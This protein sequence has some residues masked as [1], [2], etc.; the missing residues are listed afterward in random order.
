MPESSS[1]A[2]SKALIVLSETT[3]APN[4]WTRVRQSITTQAASQSRVCGERLFRYSETNVATTAARIMTAGS[5]YRIST[6]G[7]NYLHSTRSYYGK[8]QEFYRF[9]SSKVTCWSFTFACVF[10]RKAAIYLRSGEI[11]MFNTSRLNACKIL[12]AGLLIINV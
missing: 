9:V 1:A 4:A 11:I 12:L 6:I 2:K 10:R 7:E 5:L 8:Q 3:K